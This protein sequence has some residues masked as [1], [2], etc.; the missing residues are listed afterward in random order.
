MEAA[1]RVE[2]NRVGRMFVL[3]WETPGTRVTGN[4][5]KCLWIHLY[6]CYTKGILDLDTA[7]A[8]FVDEHSFY[9]IRRVIVWKPEIFNRGLFPMPSSGFEDMVEAG[10]PFSRAAIVRAWQAVGLYEV[11]ETQ[12]AF[13]ADLRARIRGQYDDKA[14]RQKRNAA[15][16]SALESE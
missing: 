14:K 6:E 5:A 8:G 11:D 10:T 15:A 2:Q 4:R 13:D 7:D 16:A 1:L 3:P 12:M 9:G